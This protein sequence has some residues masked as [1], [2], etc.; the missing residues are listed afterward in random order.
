MGFAQWLRSNSEHYLA[1]DAQRRV[2]SRYGAPMPEK[3][4]GLREH[5]WMHVF[6]PAYRLLPWG[7]RR[8]VIQALPGSHRRAWPIRSGRPQGPAI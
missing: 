8:R 3:A 7:L 6:T 2:G 4:S 1:I 5:F